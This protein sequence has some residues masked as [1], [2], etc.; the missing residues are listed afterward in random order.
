M[1]ASAELDCVFDDALDRTG[2]RAV[3][4]T[5]GLQVALAGIGGYGLL[6]GDTG[7]LVNALGA[8]GVTLLPVLLRRELAVTLRPGESLWLTGVVFLHAVGILGPYQ[9]TAWYDLLTHALSGSVVAVA[10]Y[11]AIRAVEREARG[12]AIP[13]A[14]VPLLVLDATLAA[15]VLWELF[16]FAVGAVGGYVGAGSLLTVYGVDDVVTDLVFTGLGGLVAAIVASGHVRHLSR[17]AAS[18]LR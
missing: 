9:T 14:I 15:G 18:A 5:R 2:S 12:V 4:L 13:A 6:L 11:V 7:V 10:G 3:P 8:L 16:E 17:Q 1:G